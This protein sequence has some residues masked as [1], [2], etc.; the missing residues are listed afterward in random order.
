MGVLGASGGHPN[1]WGHPD[2]HKHMGVVNSMPS[3]CQT[4]MTLFYIPLCERYGGVGGIRRE[5]KCMGAS[6]HPQTY[7]SCKLNAPKW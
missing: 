6:I 2:T 1:A 5:S 7:G 4:Y 3:K